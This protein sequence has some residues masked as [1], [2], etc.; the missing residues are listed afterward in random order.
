MELF[1]TLLELQ[2]R[3]A[4]NPVKFYVVCPQN[5]TAGLF[6]CLPHLLREA[7]Q[8]FLLFFLVHCPSAVW[9]VS[10]LSVFSCFFYVS[11]CL[12]SL[13]YRICMS[14]LS[15]VY[16]LHIENRSFYPSTP[17]ITSV[18]A[19]SSILE[20]IQVLR[21]Q[22]A[23][24]ILLLYKQQYV[25]TYAVGTAAVANELPCHHTRYAT[26]MTY[27]FYQVWNR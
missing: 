13:I 27:T 19:D 25:A 11:F 22:S 3:F 9:F 24:E 5:G 14:C 12:L 4:D 18:S 10:L 17:S 1:L 21:S 26:G 20:E 7:R 23:T 2:S 16:V 8:M 6:K 15:Y